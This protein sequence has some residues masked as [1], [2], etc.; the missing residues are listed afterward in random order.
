M[1]SWRKTLDR[2]GITDPALREAYT[3]Q[4]GVV[5]GFDRA[6]YAAVRLLLPAPL[7]PDALAA[8]AF[9]HHGDNLLDRGADGRRAFG[10]WEEQ[11]RAALAGADPADALTRA[12]AHTLTRRPV[13][14]GIVAD[15]LVAAP[16][17]AE[18]RGFATEDDFQAYVDAYSL[19]AFLLVAGLL[20]P[21]GGF[22]AYRAACRTFIEA[23]QRLDFLE[24][25][26]EDLAEGRLGVPEDALARH[27]LDRAA[28]ERDPDPAS[29]AAL[30]REQAGLVRAGLAGARGLVDLVPGPNRPMV[31]ALI[32]LQGHR[33]RGAERAGATL[34]RRPAPRPLGPALLTL[35][36]AYASTLRHRAR[37]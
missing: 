34:A 25:M 13:L 30:V 18:W 16:A 6:S 29:V 9:M 10:A 1:T 27:G 21:D 11:V 28:L 3:A 35:L 4:R 24:D 20:A 22:D 33:L 32:T 15:Y 36:R 17:D 12:L 5:A 7:V 23:A 2:A 8:T 19:P 14:R 26:A 31:R 37:P